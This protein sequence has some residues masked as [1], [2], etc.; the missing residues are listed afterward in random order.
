MV[1]GAC[2]CLGDKYEVYSDPRGLGDVEAQ[3]L[4]P[5][6]I[7]AASEILRSSRIILNCLC[8]GFGPKT[9]DLDFMEVF[10]GA[11]SIKFNLLPYSSY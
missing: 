10:A 9:E 4:G 6:I 5:A 7:S 2:S 8:S 3:H 1:R 11:V